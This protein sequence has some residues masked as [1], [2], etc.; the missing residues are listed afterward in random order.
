MMAIDEGVKEGDQIGKF[1]VKNL[2]SKI[3]PNQ[4]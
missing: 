1:I 4:P 2:S 3:E